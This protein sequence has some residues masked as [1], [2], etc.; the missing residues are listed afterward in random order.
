M[1]ILFTWM[2][3]LPALMKVK[4]IYRWTIFTKVISYG[5]IILVLASLLHIAWYNTA[6]WAMWVIGSQSLLGYWRHKLLAQS[7]LVVVLLGFGL[8]Y[9]MELLRSIGESVYFLWIGFVS[10]AC[11]VHIGIWYILRIL[12]QLVQSSE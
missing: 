12:S 10:G 2:I 9:L 11:I 8:T 3:L 4:G 6:L 1:N 7:F 5:V